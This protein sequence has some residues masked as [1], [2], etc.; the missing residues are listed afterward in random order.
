MSSGLEEDWLGGGF[1]SGVAGKSV[2]PEALKSDAL[3]FLELKASSAG[4]EPV[5]VEPLLSGSSH[6]PVRSDDDDFIKSFD[7]LNLDDD[8]KSDLYS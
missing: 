5:P 2:A 3:N 6:S 4:E 1:H 7:Y 8:E